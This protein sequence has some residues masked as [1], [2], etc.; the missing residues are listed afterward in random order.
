MPDDKQ[1][2]LLF[3][4]E[5]TPGEGATYKFA[6]ADKKKFGKDIITAADIG[7]SKSDVPYYTNS[8]QLPVGMTDDLFETLDLQDEFQC[9]YTGGTVLHIYMG[10]RITSVDSVKNLVKKIAMNY[11]LPYFSIT[12]TFS[13]CPKHGYIAGEHKYCPICDTER[14]YKTGMP[15]DEE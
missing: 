2:N 15:F 9:K 10:E 3:N 11:K 13:I 4:L 12:P 7:K 5:A 1:N 8:S 14:G 6:K